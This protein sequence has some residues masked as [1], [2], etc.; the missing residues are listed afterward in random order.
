MKLFISFSYKKLK[1]NIN[2]I[3]EIF[4]LNKFPNKISFNTT[5]NNIK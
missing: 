4:Y 5:L 1:Y 2:N 3:S